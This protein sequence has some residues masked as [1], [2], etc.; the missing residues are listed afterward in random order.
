MTSLVSLS[1]IRVSTEKTKLTVISCLRR[2]QV[3]KIEKAES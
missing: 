1:T 3:G 2:Y